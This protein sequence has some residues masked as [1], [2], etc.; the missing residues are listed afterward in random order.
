M[1]KIS[2][3]CWLYLYY[4]LIWG[5]MENKLFTTWTLTH[6]I[7]K[8]WKNQWLI[9]YKQRWPDLI[10]RVFIERFVFFYIQEVLSTL[11]AIILP[12]CEFSFFGHAESHRPFFLWAVGTYS[13]TQQITAWSIRDA[14]HP[15][16]MMINITIRIV[17]T[18]TDVSEQDH[19]IHASYELRSLTE[20]SIAAPTQPL[21]IGQSIYF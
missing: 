16:R 19:R 10:S 4:L 21:P 6:R 20:F 15:S 7:L 9:D 5:T 1:M 17:L 18:R 13:L 12:I 11:F 2:A 3:S 14:V 8:N